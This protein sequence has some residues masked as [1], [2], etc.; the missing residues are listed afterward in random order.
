VKGFIQLYKDN[1]ENIP[2]D[3]LLDEVSGIETTIQDFMMLSLNYREKNER[4]NLNQII[5]ELY[6]TIEITAHRKGVWI[7]LYLEKSLINIDADSE[8]IK[9]LISNL[10]KY[11]LQAM[12]RGGILTIRT[13]SNK[14]QVTLQVAD[15]GTNMSETYLEQACNPFQ[16][17]LDDDIGLGMTVC[18]H[19]VDS[20]G[21]SIHLYSTANTGTVVTVTI[22]RT[23][24]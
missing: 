14:E 6:P 11:S 22:P 3:L 21:G 13:L 12:P 20:L 18:Q 4:L 10:T 8:R 5:A 17:N 23:A 24:G 16:S 15:S 19:V 9:A 2:W 1:P 7:E